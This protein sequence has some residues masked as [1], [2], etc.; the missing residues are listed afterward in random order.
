MALTLRFRL[1]TLRVGAVKGTV[2]AVIMA[3]SSEPTREEKIADALRAVSAYI[4]DSATIVDGDM[5]I[6]PYVRPIPGAEPL[7][8]VPIAKPGGVKP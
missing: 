1:K 6:A 7:L 4:A 8:V 2:G 5:T 3:D